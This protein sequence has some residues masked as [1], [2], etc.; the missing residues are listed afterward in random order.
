MTVIG[1]EGDAAHQ[2]NL[3]LDL[4]CHG[5]ACKARICQ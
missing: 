4:G 1:P 3:H 5:K 2:G